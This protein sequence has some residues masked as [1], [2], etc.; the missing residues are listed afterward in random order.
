MLLVDRLLS[1]LPARL[2]LPVS[3]GFRAFGEGLAVL[4]APATHLLAIFGQSLVVWLCIDATMY[5][6]NRAFG[7]DLPFHST[8]LLI[9]FLTVGVA[10][11]TPGMVGGFHESYLLAMT[12]AYGV[13]RDIAAAAGIT[14]HALTNLP[15]LVLGLLFLGREG[16]TFGK[17]A[18]M[19]ERRPADGEGASHA[20]HAAA[21]GGVAR[22]GAAR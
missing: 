15:V 22:E 11:P 13:D 18:E 5:L 4:Q 21:P 1:P 8:F 12:Q 6:N 16:L 9:G 19:T 3:R 17:V 10:V 20:S 14:A 2:S 7:L